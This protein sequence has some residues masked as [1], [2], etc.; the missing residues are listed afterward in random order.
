MDLVDAFVRYL[1]E[2][3][4]RGAITVN[5][6]RTVLEAFEQ[7]LAR[8]SGDGQR[9]RLEDAGKLE[10]AEFL[11]EGVSSEAEP[12]RSV[13][14]LRLSALRAFFDFLFRKDLVAM[15][16]A[17]KLDRQRTR[18]RA[19][20]PLSLDEYLE[21]A[22]ATERGRY[23]VRDAAIVHVFFHCALRVAEVA[24]LNVSQV[25]LT[26]RVLLDVRTKGRKWLTV[27]LNDVAAAALERYLAERA[28]RASAAD[29]PAL[30]LSGRGTRLAVRSIQEMIR[31]CGER[32]GL[33]RR[34]TPHLL[35]H[36]SATE[37]A[38]LGTELRVIR[39]ICGH[40]S[41]LTTERYVHA[42]GGARRRAVAALGAQTLKRLAETEPAR[43]GTQG[44][45]IRSGPA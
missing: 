2:E 31:A 14:N 20:V 23:P 5:R 45:A 4:M 15:N 38:E 32:A 6:Y 9:V 10:I 30:F 24:S 13:W 12:S 29:N 42:R 28:H 1:R 7:F 26:N 3:R 21:L 44:L 39:D 33:S 36:S 43:E 11:R 19:P 35:R 40:A 25:D 41:V 8:R 27:D 18:P 17:L 37:L 22:A 34:V 16:P